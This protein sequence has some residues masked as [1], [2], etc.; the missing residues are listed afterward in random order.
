MRAKKGHQAGRGSQANEPKIAGARAYQDALLVGDGTSAPPRPLFVFNVRVFDDRLLPPVLSG[1]S[2]WPQRYVVV[3][4]Q[5][6]GG[7]RGEGPLA[8]RL[9]AD[10]EVTRA[11]LDL[12]D[13]RVHLV[14][15][16]DQSEEALNAFFAHPSSVRLVAEEGA[17]ARA[18]YEEWRRKA[19]PVRLPYVSRA[20]RQRNTLSPVFR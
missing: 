1:P 4:R 7:V 5:S 16:L 13:A 17:R 12:P 9:E 20:A 18:R 15:A 14:V 11:R 19:G 6:D 8:S 10:H 3:I 2:E